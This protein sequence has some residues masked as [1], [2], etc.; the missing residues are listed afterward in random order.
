MKILSMT[1][2]FGKLDNET[3]VFSHGLNILSA[4]NEWGKSTWCAF[5]TAMLYGIDTRER[6][7]GDYLA[8]KEKY[9]PWSGKPMEG[10]VRLI[11]EGRDITI[12]R[13]TKGRT[14][15]GEFSAWE[16]ETGLPIRELTGENCGLKLLGVEKSV[17]LRTGFLRFSDLPVKADES[18][19]RR[20]NDLVT[21]GDESGDAQRLGVRLRELK[22]RC[23]H[24]HT[25]LIPEC[26]AEIRKTQEALWERQTL[27]KQCDAITDRL[28]I[29]E[30]ELETLKNHR[31]SLRW[32]D[33]QA[34]LQRLENARSDAR[35]A[36]LFERALLEKYTENPDRN[37][38]LAKIRQGERLLEEIELS[39]EEPP[40]GTYGIVL[41]AALAAV[42]LIA[43]VLMT[44]QGLLIPCILLSL[45]MLGTC[46]NLIGRQRRQR[47][48]YSIEQTRRNAKHDE[49]TKFV[50]SWRNQ[51]QVLDELDRARENSIRTK[52]HAADLEA[53]IRTAEAPDFDDTLTLDWEQ[54]LT[55]IGEGR[56]QRD[57]YRMQLAQLRGRMEPLADGE[58]LQRRLRQLQRRLEQLEQTHRAIGYAQNALEEAMHQLQ[59]RFAPQITHRAGEYLN[60][61]T[62]GVYDR[63]SIS[64]ELIV[65][66]A[67]GDETTLRTALWRSEG[68]GD[69]MYLALRLAVWETVAPHAPLILDDALIRFDQ[70]RMERAMDLLSDLAGQRQILLFSCQ[71]REKDY[72]SR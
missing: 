33:A 64:D 24:N 29:Q 69:Q 30:A 1:A 19:R 63:I 51:L 59:R 72:F 18:L 39:M 2:T 16:T 12:Q 66:A 54:T 48:W 15:M 10:T 20:L 27:Q 46:L 31:Q 9:L 49:L 26:Q 65:L 58:T 68:T 55:A 41:T 6:S 44:D 37:D 45:V 38:V 13:R 32:L 40:S 47:I 36:A 7:K 42:L 57:A 11:H 4:P 22:N 71:E 61:L 8:E 62:D 56:R 53:M 34:D 3:L 25:G 43:A 14:P 17:F 67:R 23:R 28:R 52:K 5:L 60:R 70:K 21:T 50:A 35:T